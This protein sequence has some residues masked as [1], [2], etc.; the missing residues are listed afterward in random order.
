MKLLLATVGILALISGC[1]E[2]TAVGN[3]TVTNAPVAKNAWDPDAVAR[4][5]HEKQG[6][7]GK[8]KWDPDQAA[9]DYAKRLA[10]DAEAVRTWGVP[11][12]IK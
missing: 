7:P 10:R 2:A 5:F 3:T 6:L 1:A 11:Q 12:E 9:A 4:E 8:A